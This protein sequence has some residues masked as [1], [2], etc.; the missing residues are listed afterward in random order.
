MNAAD[1]GFR[2][3]CQPSA[4]RIRLGPPR[5][6]A[7]P[8]GGQPHLSCAVRTLA[9]SG[10]LKEIADLPEP[11]G[12]S[13][14][15][16]TV[17]EPEVDDVDRISA[18][19]R[20]L[21]GGGAIF[22]SPPARI[23]N[24]P[25]QGRRAIAVNTKPTVKDYLEGVGQGLKILERCPSWPCDHRGTGCEATECRDLLH[26]AF[27]R[28]CDEADRAADR[29]GRSGTDRSV[30]GGD[31]GRDGRGRSCSKVTCRQASRSQAWRSTA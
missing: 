7:W 11:W 14:C 4:D 13:V 31:G 2:Y 20:R 25:G 10:L 9:V 19:L 24:R 23:G 28:V 6:C 12:Q 17:R 15:P 5:G 30:P 29:P 1:A 16:G 27:Q 18:E 8:G 3:D 22:C 26:P 21:S